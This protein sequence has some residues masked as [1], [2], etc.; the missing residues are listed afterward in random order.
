MPRANQGD[1]R[2]RIVR[3]ERFAL[4]ALLRPCRPFAVVVSAESWCYRCW[5][6]CGRT[7]WSPPM[8]LRGIFPFRRQWLHARSAHPKTGFHHRIKSG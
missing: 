6:A 2:S 8:P 5:R 1:D 3:A 4:A 7:K